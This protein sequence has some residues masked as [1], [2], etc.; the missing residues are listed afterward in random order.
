MR[1][2]TMR[3][4]A[5]LALFVSMSGTAGA[6]LD[7]YFDMNT[8]ERIVHRLNGEALRAR[9]DSGEGF[10][11]AP[12]PFLQPP[13]E[14]KLQP[15][16]MWH[17]GCLCHRCVHP[18]QIVHSHWGI[19][20]TDHDWSWLDVD[21]QGGFTNMANFSVATGSSDWA[22][23]R[24][25]DGYWFLLYRARNPESACC[26]TKS[27]ACGNWDAAI[28]EHWVFGCTGKLTSKTS[29]ERS[30]ST[31][32][33]SSV[34]A[35]ALGATGE[36]GVGVAAIQGSSNT[37]VTVSSLHITRGDWEFCWTRADKIAKQTPCKCG[38]EGERH[39]DPR[40]VPTP[41]DQP[42]ESGDAG[43]QIRIPGGAEAEVVETIE[44][45]GGSRYEFTAKGEA[46]VSIELIGATADYSVDEDEK[47]GHVVVAD[48][49]R[50]GPI[51]VVPRPGKN[52]PVLG[53]LTDGGPEILVVG[54]RQPKSGKKH[55]TPTF[56]G[57]T[58]AI[59]TAPNQG[60]TP[61]VVLTGITPKSGSVPHVEFSAKDEKGRR[62]VAVFLPD[63]VVTDADG[64]KEIGGRILV[65]DLET[66]N[67]PGAKIQV[68]MTDPS[69]GGPL[70]DGTV[71]RDT[72]FEDPETGEDRSVPSAHRAQPR[73]T[74]EPTQVKPGMRVTARAEVSAEDMDALEAAGYP[75]EVLEI[76]ILGPDGKEI[77]RGPAPGPV[78][79]TTRATKPGKYQV[80]AEI[81]IG[82]DA[83]AYRRAQ[84]G[85]EA[86]ARRM[87]EA[88]HG[89]PGIDAYARE[90]LDAKTEALKRL[91][92]V[93]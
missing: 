22:D 39:E 80:R 15:T 61:P 64:K 90:L 81:Q 43:R 50:K 67:R 79:G 2:L 86:A 41:R 18:V 17:E 87:T 73:V 12:D 38:A 91:A 42:Q 8:I 46:P 74:V 30:S 54:F 25:V 20:V 56:R 11:D 31:S 7:D 48:P 68:T 24:A 83:K 82:R 75:R 66:W 9:A 10:D 16:Y 19:F 33:S 92:G 35:S 63:V 45:L 57:T 93:K 53:R 85:A 58:K 4:L 84:A 77:A 23:A 70:Y 51:P 26:N 62:Q 60:M 34:S 47:G 71:G 59:P 1:S 52:V 21:D 49:G 55:E 89:V 76:Q 6:D 37:D 65:N 32:A 78:V 14:A 28:F 72:R 40:P 88:L 13:P 5:V 44:G 27:H 29:S 36:D 3:I 69:T